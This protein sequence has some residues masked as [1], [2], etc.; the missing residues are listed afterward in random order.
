MQADLGC[1]VATSIRWS[2]LE[3]K[4]ANQTFA[5]HATL[6]LPLSNVN[7]KTV[8][9]IKMKLGLFYFLPEFRRSF[10]IAEQPAPFKKKIMFTNTSQAYGFGPGN[11]DHL[12]ASCKLH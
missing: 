10:L 4:I 9:L 11:C 12:K 1:S 3:N 2:S 6:F 5:A 7:C 8:Y